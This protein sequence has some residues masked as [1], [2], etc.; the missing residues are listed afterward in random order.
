MAVECVCCGKRSG[1]GCEVDACDYCH[2]VQCWQCG[3]RSPEGSRVCSACDATRC[4]GC[5]R[6]IQESEEHRTEPSAERCAVCLAAGCLEA[7]RQVHAA[8]VGGDAEL[9]RS[10][11]ARAAHLAKPSVYFVR[12]GDRIKIGYS[13]NVTKRMASLASAFASPLTLLATMPGPPSLE[14]E[15]HAKF[16]AHR[17]RGEWFRRAPDLDAFIVELNAGS[18]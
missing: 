7:R 4:D 17:V 11:R 13:E 12:C 9:G 3:M 18:A 14:R 15:L 16:A 8:I 1:R 10:R 5:G 6:T 2:R